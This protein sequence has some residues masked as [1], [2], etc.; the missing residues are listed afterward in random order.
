MLFGII[1]ITAGFI[2]FGLM[3]DYTRRAVVIG[4]LTPQSGIVTISSPT[5]GQLLW[6]VTNGESVIAG[7]RLAQVSADVADAAGISMANIKITNI[8]D[9]LALATK[10]QTLL[11]AQ[12]NALLVQR[13]SALE[14]FD[15]GT[16]LLTQLAMSQEE[17][18]ALLKDQLDRSNNLLGDNLNIVQPHFYGPVLSKVSGTGGYMFRA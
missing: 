9:G 17:E 18:L 12:I 1:A 2:L 7:N 13:V 14:R 5:S 4:H 10:R 3:A 8:Q 15:A 11:L 16:A 6:D